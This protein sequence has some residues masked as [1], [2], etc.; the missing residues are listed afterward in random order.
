MPAQGGELIG[1]IGAREVM[2]EVRVRRFASSCVESPTTP[3]GEMGPADS[4]GTG[5]IPIDVF[6]TPHSSS[7]S[8]ASSTS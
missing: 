3:R 1:S 2:H 8:R 7:R 6:A 5:S 4:G